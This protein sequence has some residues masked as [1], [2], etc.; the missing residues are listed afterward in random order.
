[1]RDPGLAAGLLCLCFACDMPGSNDRPDVHGHRGCRG[2]MPENTLPGFLQA[3]DLG[4]DWLEL[5]VVIAGDG[6]VIVSHEP[7]MSA[8]ICLDRN[9]RPFQAEH[10]RLLNIHRMTLADMALFDCGTKPHPGFP[11]QEHFAATKPTLDSVV[12]AC[13]DHATENGLPE[14]RYS[15]EIKSDPALYGEFQPLPAPFVRSV[16]ARIT[17]LGI[18]DRCILQSFDPSVLQEVARTSPGTR[19]ALL[20]DNHDGLEKNLQRLGFEPAIY[21]PMF[22]LVDKELVRALQARN[23]E[24]VVWTVNRKKDIRRMV[25]LGVDGIISDYPDRVI[26]IL[27]E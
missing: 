22:E 17:E 14:P 19:I 26:R 10:E 4:C 3:L 16:M 6:S 9:G 8:E 25:D 1:M 21:S 2:L 27:D 15:V 18:E 5:D 12:K 23:I 20:V 13:E 7:W 24:L 11:D